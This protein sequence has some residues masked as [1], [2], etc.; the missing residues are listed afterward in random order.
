MRRRI[1]AQMVTASWYGGRATPFFRLGIDLLT[2]CAAIPRGEPEV[3]RTR[4]SIFGRRAIRPS[5][6]R[7][8]FSSAVRTAVGGRVRRTLI[9]DC[10]IK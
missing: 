9:P 10:R 7:K 3:D 5:S 4:F 1:G 6:P 2:S 8:E